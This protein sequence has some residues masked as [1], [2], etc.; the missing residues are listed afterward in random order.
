MRI[1]TSALVHTRGMGAKAAN[2]RTNIGCASERVGP[3][4]QAINDSCSVEDK[5]IK[6]DVPGFVHVIRCPTS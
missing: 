4:I 3:R 1:T 6:G 2:S 5:G